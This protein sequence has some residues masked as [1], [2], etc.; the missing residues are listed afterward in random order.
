[1]ARTKSAFTLRYTDFPGSLKP[2]V[3]YR[4]FPSTKLGL[5]YQSC[6]VNKLKTSL[7]LSIGVNRVNGES[8]PKTN[9]PAHERNILCI[10]FSF[11]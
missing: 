7:I 5:K 3:E 1:M 9:F 8:K 4:R 10:E 2:S 6:H 11:I